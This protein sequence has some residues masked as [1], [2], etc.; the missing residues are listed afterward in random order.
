MSI[1]LNHIKRSSTLLT[2]REMFKTTMRYKFLSDIQ[3]PKNLT[4]CSMA[5]E[6]EAFS[7]IASDNLKLCNFCGGKLFNI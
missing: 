1:V 2:I 6:K 5:K 7:K 4:A 3:T